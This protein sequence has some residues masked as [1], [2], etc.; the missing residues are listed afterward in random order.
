MIL[1]AGIIAAGEGTRLRRAFP[2]TPKPLVPLAGRPLVHWVVASLRA[3]G[4]GRIA[5]LLNSRGKAARDHLRTH[6]TDISWTFLECDSPSSWESFRIVSSELASRE[7]RF[8]V[9][10]VDALVPGPDAARFAREADAALSGDLAEAALALTR[11]VEDE[12]PLWAQRNASGYVDG[13]GDCVLHREYVTCGLYALSGKLARTFPGASHP[14][15]RA[16]LGSALRSGTRFLGIPLART[17][18]VDRPQDLETARDFVL[19]GGLPS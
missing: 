12:N 10:T 16:F 15:L 11:F 9:S 14:S 17:I 5:I 8:L 6:F 3:A 7:E 4:I 18:D 2:A 1:S 19:A 13:L